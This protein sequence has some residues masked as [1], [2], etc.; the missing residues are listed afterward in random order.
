MRPFILMLLA[1]A[2]PALGQA[3][4]NE[5]E[6]EPEPL[7]SPRHML[8]VC[9]VPPMLCYRG[10]ATEF[11]TIDLGA[12]GHPSLIIAKAGMSVHQPIWY[13]KQATHNA[14]VSGSY[15]YMN[16]MLDGL[17]MGGPMVQFGYE[18]VGELSAFSLTAGAINDTLGP[19]MTPI[20]GIDFMAVLR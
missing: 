13:T 2:W 15:L 3:A 20:I 6:A 7:E 11:M 17:P 5:P 18:R 10:W 1:C 16:G 9:V 19:G 8:G 14:L 4:W 12:F